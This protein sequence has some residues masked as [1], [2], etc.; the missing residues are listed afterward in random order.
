LE[1][2]SDKRKMPVYT[3]GNAERF[4]MRRSLSAGGSLGPGQYRVDRDF[5]EDEV[6][7]I[8]TTFNTKCTQPAPKYTF[9]VDER[10][11]QDGC[12]KGISQFY[13]KKP[14][15]LGPGQY[16]M[17]VLESRTNRRVSIKYTLP[18]AKETQ[19]A[20]R[21]R[22]VAN[23]SPGPGVY[24]S[25][26]KFDEMDRDRAKETKRLAKRA[27]KGCWADKQFGQIFGAM[28]LSGGAPP[29]ETHASA[30]ALRVNAPAP[31]EADAA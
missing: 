31:K 2:F 17:P 9:N 8:G 12:L 13:Q 30:P 23:T 18:K 21:E 1:K 6:G 15:P 29:G 24:N 20:I 10:I 3:I 19:E 4:N 27:A 25:A 5:P 26:S 11:A 14:M 7:E 28:K 16:P 22:K